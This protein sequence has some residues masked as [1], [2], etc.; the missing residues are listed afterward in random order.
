MKKE[1]KNKKGLGGMA[2]P[3]KLST[4]SSNYSKKK[5]LNISINSFHSCAG[6]AEWLTQSAVNRCPSGH[7]GPIPTAGAV[8]S[9]KKFG[10]GI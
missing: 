7:V 1:M 9:I 6:M 8:F 2:K 5:Y 4:D 10:G 3:K